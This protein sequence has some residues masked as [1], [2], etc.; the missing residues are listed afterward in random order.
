MRPVIFEF[1]G[2]PIHGYGLM[3]VL[4]YLLTVYMGTRIV[5][6]WGL[7]DIF[8]DL[9]IL[10]LLSG[11]LGGRT[12]FYILNYSTDFQGRSPFAFF[13][14]WEGGLVLYGGV[15]AGCLGG[16][17]YMKWKK[18]SVLDYMDVAGIVAPIG[19]AFG[20][21]GCFMNGCCFGRVC[22]ESYP[23]GIHFPED[24]PPW[25]HQFHMGLLERGEM[26]EAVHPAQLYQAGHDFLLFF[27]LLLY[28]GRGYA[29]RGAGM[30]LLWLLYGIGRFFIEGLRDDTPL[31]LTGLTVSQNYSLVVVLVFGALLG[32]IYSRSSDNRSTQV[33]V[34]P[35]IPE[36][37]E[38]T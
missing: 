26:M 24:S 12:M 14:I 20:R 29:P 32:W 3:I 16:L 22:S 2:L 7:A 35:I 30:P 37:K 27:L 18:L 13:A 38:N 33:P 28:V 36:K 8:Y 23:L 21:L 4:G 19:L 1:F 5:R 9:S 11:I 6:R 31:T 17:A 15:T 25:F 10:M 34:I